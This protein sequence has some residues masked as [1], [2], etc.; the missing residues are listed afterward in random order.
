[1][2]LFFFF[3]SVFA[4]QPKEKLSLSSSAQAS[5]VKRYWSLDSTSGVH[6]GAASGQV[7]TSGEDSSGESGHFNTPLKK[8]SVE[9][10]LLWNPDSH[11]LTVEISKLKCN[12]SKFAKVSGEIVLKLQLVKSPSA[13]Q[14]LFSLFQKED[15]FRK[16][17]VKEAQ[18]S[19]RKRKKEILFNEK[20]ELIVSDDKLDEHSLRLVVC[21]V[22]KDCGIE[23]MGEAMVLLRPLQSSTSYSTAMILQP[24]PKVNS[25]KIFL[26]FKSLKLTRKIIDNC[27]ND[28]PAISPIQKKKKKTG[29]R[30]IPSLFV[31]FPCNKTSTSMQIFSTNFLRQWQI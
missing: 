30:S 8:S 23:E 28:S 13:M 31:F 27:M 18:T 16:N 7:T 9:F 29:Y 15:E 5:K 11:M 6:E 12:F 10:S 26:T 1:M 14:N 17:L 21:T 24:V 4:S 2:H 3:S 22:D 25:L 19:V 20:I